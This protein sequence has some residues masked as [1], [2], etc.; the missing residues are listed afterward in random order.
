MNHPCILCR[1][2]DTS[3]R[4]V[5][6]A[7]I[8]RALLEYFDEPLPS[9]VALLDYDMLEC[10]QCKIV[11]ALPMIPGDGTF[12]R[13]VTS[14]PNYYPSV[15]W[16]WRSVVEKIARAAAV[17]R[18]SVLDVGCGSGDFLAK[19]KSIPGVDAWGVD[20]TMTSVEKAR[21]RGLK[22]D[23]ADLDRFLSLNPSR[24]FDFVTSFH[25]VE[26]VQN[27]ISFMED[28][29][30]LL[31]PIGGVALVSA[32]LSPMSIEY[33]W[34]DPLNYPPHHL[35]RWSR[36]SLQKLA[37]ITGFQISITTSPAGSSVSRA[38]RALALAKRGVLYS[39][40][41]VQKV[42]L[43]VRNFPEFYAACRMQSRR[44]KI[45]GKT[46]GDTFLAAFTLHS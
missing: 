29:K 46:A 41:R 10:Q 8:R 7:T 44:E 14:H 34:F 36:T 16:E 27:P 9:D 26:H 35:S 45:N 12:Y 23:C 25:C 18:T 1:S 28:I 38:L 43:A 6:S 32:P 22:A 3:I 40:G 24:R 20:T 2:T 37:E 15:R 13:W 33:G 11:S 42:I 30:R 21:A 39:G 5:G 17:R 19:V 31:N 4:K